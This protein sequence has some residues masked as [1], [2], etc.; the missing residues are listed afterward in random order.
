MIKDIN[1][2]NPRYFILSEDDMLMQGDEYYDN[3]EDR[4]YP[5]E[6]THIG[7]LYKGPYDYLHFLVIRRKN[8]KFKNEHQPWI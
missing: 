5:I 8:P 2:P 4:W 6:D 3:V 7:D 1:S